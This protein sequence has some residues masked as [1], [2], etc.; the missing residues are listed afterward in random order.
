MTTKNYCDRQNSIL[1]TWLKGFEDYVFY[2][3][4]VN[5]IGKQVS[6][7][8][9]SSYEYCGLKQINEFKRILNQNL[10]DFYD[11]FLFCDDDTVVNIKKIQQLIQNLDPNYVYGWNST[12]SWPVDPDLNYCSGGA[13]FLVS[14]NIFKNIKIF[15]KLYPNGDD[16]HVKMYEFSDVQAGLFFRDNKINYKFI[17]G[18]YYDVPKT[19]GFDI[20]TEEG[21]EKIKNSYTFHFGRTD[22]L[23]SLISNIFNAEIKSNV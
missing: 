3:D 8:S 14:S 4:I 1:Q 11:Y 9:K 10:F 2:T 23:R 7:T 6:V 22:E 18:F 19:F 13:G 12:G 5:D 21:R 15:P 16:L 20:T 17:E